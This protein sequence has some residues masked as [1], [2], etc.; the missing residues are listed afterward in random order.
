MDANDTAKAVG[1]AALALI[2]LIIF[3][4]IFFYLVVP[5]VAIWAAITGYTYYTETQGAQIRR[6]KR[7]AAQLTPLIAA[8]PAPTVGKLLQP[9]ADA[10]Y[11]NETFSGVRPPPSAATAIDWGR[12]VDQLSASASRPSVVHLAHAAV[13][14]SLQNFLIALPD[15]ERGEFHTRAIDVIADVGGAINEIVLPF[16][17]D[18]LSNAGLF[19]SL[20][21]QLNR[22]IHQM[23][24]VPYVSDYD[25]SSKLVLPSK[26]KGTA[27]QLV[28]GY[29]G[30]TPLEDLFKM[31]IDFGIPDRL[32]FEGTW[33]I[34]PPGRGKTTLLSQLLATDLDNVSA[35]KASV[36]LMDSKGDLIDHA[37]RL[38]RF[39]PGGDL[40]GRLVLIEPT[41]NLSLNPLDMGASA[42][43]TIA[44]LEYVFSSLLDT[45]PTPLQSTLFR[46]VL[47][48]M[49]EIP[50]ANF[51]TFR[52]F[53]TEG[54]QPFE[55]YIRE[56]HPDD[57]DFFLKPDATTGKSEYDSRTYTETKQ[58]LLWRIR[59]LTTKVP[60]L[61]DMFKAPHTRIDLATEMDAGKVIIID[62]SAATLSAGSEF[63]S[64]FF[65]ALILA[66]A[67]QRAGRSDSSKLPC[68]VYIDECD[69]VISRDT[70]ITEI[71]HRCRSQKIGLVLAH[72]EL[73]QIKSDDVKAA[74]ANCAVRIA[75]S[76]D[77]AS[78]LAPKLRTTPDMLRSL[79]RGQFALF[80]RD[81]TPRP[82]I[83]TV[84]PDGAVWNWPKMTESQYRA[85]QQEMTDRYC[86]STT[87]LPSPVTAAPAAVT[88][89]P[90]P[91]RSAPPAAE[92]T[93]TGP[94]AWE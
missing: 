91:G 33:V 81:L 88:P 19:A 74:L 29:L 45:A 85:I 79:Q 68:F 21:S 72:Q 41:G 25:A 18:E 15:L 26:H 8:P 50:G 9:I 2:G 70:S 53:L 87:P 11:R 24:D 1:G 42:G 92:V 57:R 13:K 47:L 90:A 69:T 52:R 6:L 23:S 38:Q 64:R 60:I 5:I 7:K 46:S 51:D 82:L 40:Y 59:D 37:R 31:P 78:Q 75:N 54:W 56:M 61:R 83:V 12:Y 35:G 76:D 20:R 43:H 77:E 32:R 55:Q 73:Q 58:Q 62:N 71:I 39:A 3:L 17:T 49:Q 86:F 22:N 94:A 34:A 44:L 65:I 14:E 84:D 10:L 89:P 80:M 36:I 48:A 30:H 93:G 27:A 67:Q 16:Y 66:A 63:F 4:H 28:H